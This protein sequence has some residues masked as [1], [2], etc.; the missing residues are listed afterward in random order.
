MILF[1]TLTDQTHKA[2]LVTGARGGISANV[3]TQPALTHAEVL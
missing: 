1:A 3:V 2:Y